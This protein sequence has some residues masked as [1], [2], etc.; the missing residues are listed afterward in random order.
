MKKLILIQLVAIALLF[1]F[2]SFA[3]D[4]DLDG[5]T[6]AA[7]DCND[8]DNTVYPGAA[9]LIDGQDNDCDGNLVSAE[10]DLDGDLYIA[11]V[12]DA[13]GWD[14]AA[15]LGQLDCDDDN[16]FI[17]PGAP[18]I[19]GDGIDEDCNGMEICFVDSDGDTHG[20]GDMFEIPTTNCYLAGGSNSN[21]DCDDYN[22]LMFPGNTE[23]CDGYDN[24]C[25][26]FVDNNAVDI[27]T[28]YQDNDWDGYGNPAV[29]VLSC[30]QPGGYVENNLDCDD[31]HGSSYPGATEFCDGIDND[32]DGS[33]D[34][35]AIDAP[36]WFADSDEDGYG[37]PG[38]FINSCNP[39]AGYVDND[40]DCDDNDNSVYPMAPEYCD[41]KDND[42]N[43]IDDDYPVD[44]QNWYVDWDGD[45]FGDPNYYIYDCNPPAGYVSDNQDCD[46]NNA[47]VHPGAVEICD[48]IDNNCNMIVDQ[49]AIDATWW[50]ADYDEDGYGCAADSI[51]SCEQPWNGVYYA[52]N[53]LDCIEGDPNSNPD[54][55]EFCDGVD[56]DCDGDIDENV[57]WAPYWFADA[58][59][60]G[61]G[62]PNEFVQACNMPVGYVEN[63]MDCDDAD[64]DVNPESPEICNG[65]DDNCNGEI[66]EGY[67]SY[68]YAENYSMC[69]GQTYTWHGNT[70]SSS[71]NYIYID[72]TVYGC[73]VYNLQL[74]VHPTYYVSDTADLCSGSAYL[75]HDSI[76]TLAGSYIFNPLTEAGCDSIFE[77]TLNVNPGSGY[78]FHDTVVVCSDDNFSWHGNHYA[79]S[80]IFQDHYLT[81]AGCDS[82]YFLHLTVHPA[83]HYNLTTNAVM[84]DTVNW[85]GQT[86]TASG[87]YYDSYQT[88]NG[89][90][91]VYALTIYFKEPVLS[92][93]WGVSMDGGPNNVGYIFK[94]DGNGDNLTI[95]HYFNEDGFYA[96]GGLTVGPDGL[97]YGITLLGGDFEGGV[98][99]SIDPAT[100]SIVTRHSFDTYDFGFPS[101]TLLLAS[102]NK[103]YGMTAGIENFDPGSLFE[104]D[105]AT[106]IFQTKVLLEQLTGDFPAGVTLAEGADHLLYGVTQRGG[107][108]NLGVIFTYDFNSETYNPV[109]HFDIGSNNGNVTLAADGN[110][111]GIHSGA[112]N[113]YKYT[114]PGNI[115]V[116]HYFGTDSLGRHPQGRLE[117]DSAG[118]L[119]GITRDGGLSNKGI[120][121]AFDT[122]YGSFTKLA[123]MAS[124]GAEYPLGS[125]TRASN[126]KLYG[127]TL[128]VPGAEG[129]NLF[130]YDPLTGSLVIKYTF[131][132]KEDEMYNNPKLVEVCQSPLFSHN[133]SSLDLCN[134]GDTL[135]Y[136][137]VSGNGL[138][139]S[140]QADLGSGFVNLSND[141][142]YSGV[143]DD[144]LFISGANAAMNGYVYR[145]VVSSTCPSVNVNSNTSELNIRGEYHFTDNASIC[146]GSAY[147]WQNNTYNTAGTYYAHYNSM[148]GCDSTYQLT[149][150]TTPG[151]GYAFHD[152]ASICEGDVYTWHGMQ[153]SESGL[154]QDSYTTLA[155]CDSSY[156][157]HLQVNPVYEFNETAIICDGGAYLWQGTIYTVEGNYH[158][159][160]TSSL[161]CD[162]VY[163]L[164]L[165]VDYE[166]PG[167]AS[168]EEATI[169]NGS[170][171]L[172]MGN[173]YTGPGMYE[174]HRP[175]WEEPGFMLCDSAFFL[176]LHV[177][178]GPGFTQLDTLEI[179]GGDTAFYHGNSYT[180][181]GLYVVSYLTQGGCDSTYYLNLTVH[182]SYLFAETFNSVVGD[183]V[184]WHGNQYFSDANVFENYTTAF[185]CDSVYSFS[186]HFYPRYEGPAN[187]ELWGMT[188]SGGEN[189]LGCIFKTDGSGENQTVVYSFELGGGVGPWG[190]LLYASNGKLYGMTSSGGA[191][192]Q[193]TI[194]EYDMANNLYSDDF[195]F[196]VSNGANP[197]GSLVEGSN[198]L[199][200][201]MTRDGG[202]NNQGVVFSFDPETHQY[203]KLFNL[204][205]YQLGNPNGSLAIDENGHLW[206]LTMVGPTNFGEDIYEGFGAAFDYNPQ[207]GTVTVKTPAVFEDGA[208]PSGTLIELLPDELL[209]GVTS[210]GPVMFTGEWY[211]YDMNGGT[212]FYTSQNDQ[213]NTIYTFDLS[214]PN[215]GL[216]PIG[217]LVQAQNGKLYGLTSEGGTNYVGVLYEVNPSSNT[218]SKKKDLQVDMT[219]SV[220]LGP[221]MTTCNG[222]LL[223]MTSE[224]GEF[225]YGTI[226]RYDAASNT[227]TKTHDFDIATGAYPKYS[228][229]IEVPAVLRI[230]DQ[231]TDAVVCRESD[232]ALTVN[233]TGNNITYQWQISHGSGFS[234]IAN[235]GVFSGT[236]S[237]QLQI[238]DAPD[239][240]N[241]VDFRCII[242]S[243]CPVN[244]IVSDTIAIQVNPIYQFAENHAI[245]RGETYSWHNTVY[246]DNGTFEA[247]YLTANGCDSI[248]TLNLTVHEL[249]FVY[250]GDD[251]NICEGSTISLTGSG[252]A[253]QYNWN[254]NVVNSM[255]FQ[256][257]AS[258][259]YIVTGIDML[260][261][262]RDYDTIHVELQPTPVVDAGVALTVCE[263][264]SV[265]L[266]ASGTATTYIWNNGV[267]NNVP[268]VVT[269]SDVFTVTGYDNY[270]CSD[271][272]FTLVSVTPVPAVTLVLSDTVFCLTDNPMYLSGIPSAGTFY[273][274][275][276]IGNMFYPDVA[277]P[278]DHDI[279]YSYTNGG[280]CSGFDTTTVSVIDCTGMDENDLFN[281]SIFPNPTS[282][283]LSITFPA[284]DDYTLS[285]ID[286]PGQIVQTTQISAQK[287]VQLDL[288]SFA[289][290]VYMLKIEN[291]EG[292]VLKRV[293]VE[294]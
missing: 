68:I 93:L 273:G 183:T 76:Y 259:I 179:C 209:Y 30:F 59:N 291:A 128:G 4:N 118:M 277:G 228:T 271:Q 14:G 143:N 117:A 263:G 135:L 64:N 36:M 180:E 213:F 238:N 65:K 48:G 37:D 51:Y 100:E 287:T 120:I 283:Q 208:Y 174:V 164:E 113:L 170:S 274:T 111:Y 256:P 217:G 134:P 122:E 161:G 187:T 257:L 205:Q 43:G 249:P 22:A 20:S 2:Q 245:C 110:L 58:D 267:T 18:E 47:A 34:E 182:P 124:V 89:C 148:Y 98:L 1:P 133:L 219:G 192:N 7:G 226:F 178:G 153:Y 38:I 91:S 184:E 45:T 82:T 21:D 230:V 75:W 146:T 152:T 95:V 261:G 193:G 188:S 126:G 221:M 85:R 190:D 114:G 194:F 11:G 17:H 198:G 5:W 66:D 104:Y 166:F 293:V 224:G 227:V 53:K 15:I 80:G 216:H 288:N 210:M 86:I 229:L 279:I 160:Y 196:G 169:C 103:L 107:N 46:D 233:A 250:A 255:S 127:M 243:Q 72:E 97:L 175:M 87:T 191:N 147:L 140:W 57:E 199:L 19:P 231:P 79:S 290:G 125:L 275:G 32:C 73:D 258:N 42:C 186:I 158:R 156:F 105:P 254:N 235:Q 63:E 244:S 137:N 264:D 96:D 10:M 154:Y 270:G 206:G 102:N 12:I 35:D 149:L 185:G 157:L 31:I 83:Y 99:Y 246:N 119:W 145:C 29:F 106:G 50:Y 62:N 253:N 49:D 142:V 176:N 67:E 251:M 218:V 285:F 6:V 265:T 195:S 41:G 167:Y 44:G 121:Y 177:S 237:S 202:D 211:D 204:A 77:L 27:Q 25:D 171:Y 215:N 222:S 173:I 268:F 101:G 150:T 129:G 112:N 155:G 56:N 281:V 276:V 23:V 248:Y 61:Y 13:G 289:P 247:N 272:D 116:M 54:A 151:T 189:N 144:T 262:C 201:G 24:D 260:T 109:Y 139:Y 225:G 78:A 123:D 108:N 132:I 172:W 71:G 286:A 282:G 294:R 70:Y 39:V 131:G 69:Q 280:G 52:N 141:A 252:T 92:E 84:G 214:N 90:D 8:G 266:T 26:G 165:I 162:S 60:D 234:N 40:W 240:L 9:E 163:H 292:F 278:G 242:T 284:E 168:V 81:Q 94:T 88:Q 3:Q 115:D 197:T 223:G 16:D 28:W 220:P 232:H 33:M 269:N 136:V 55:P 159:F 212:V 181:S 207:T 239:S 241:N 203:Q 138:T 236:T 130:Q 74:T 200:Y